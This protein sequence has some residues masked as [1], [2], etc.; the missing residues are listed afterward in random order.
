MSYGCLELLQNFLQIS[1]NCKY[2]KSVR[3]QSCNC[4][5]RSVR[6]CECANKL[7]SNVIQIVL[8]QDGSYEVYIVTNFLA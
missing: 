7:D 4:H 2:T 8:F 6:T 5:Y 3:I 1:V